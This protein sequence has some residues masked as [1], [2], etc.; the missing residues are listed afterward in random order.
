[1][2]KWLSKREFKKFFPSRDREEA[3]RLG[4]RKTAP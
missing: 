3:V 1:M 2:A 4:D